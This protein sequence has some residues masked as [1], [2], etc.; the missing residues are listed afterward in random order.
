[1]TLSDALAHVL[2]I[3]G[4]RSASVVSTEG[5]VVE[6]VSEEEHDLEFVAGLV[7]SSLASSQA[8]AETLGAS[9]IEQAM[10]EFENGPVLL[11]PLA[12]PAEGFVVMVSLASTGELGRVRFQLR[13]LLGDIADAV[14]AHAH[15]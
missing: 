7:A 13:R 14:A 9:P 5:F 12:P 2:A 10:I 1:M 15:P 4:V 6:G 11:V 8:L 3:P